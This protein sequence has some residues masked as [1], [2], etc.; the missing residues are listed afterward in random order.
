[1]TAS[2][3]ISDILGLSESLRQV[4]GV[5]ISKICHSSASDKTLVQVGYL[6]QR[7]YFFSTLPT[8]VTHPVMTHFRGTSTN[9]IHSGCHKT[10]GHII[11]DI[12]F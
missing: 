2:T 6:G 3:D 12:Q 11:S 4:S 1:M 7:K 8:K 9:G 10:E 5:I